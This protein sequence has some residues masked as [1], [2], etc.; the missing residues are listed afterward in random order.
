[1]VSLLQRGG[2][3]VQ[4]RGRLDDARRHAAIAPAL[5]ESDRG[6]A[7]ERDR[8][9]KGARAAR[10]GHRRIRELGLAQVNDVLLYARLKDLGMPPDTAWE[11]AAQIRDKLHPVA[12]VAAAKILKRLGDK[13]GGLGVLSVGAAGATKTVVGA[14]AGIAAGAA[15]GSVVPGIGTAV[16]AIA[17]LIAG[18][19][20]KQSGDP[21]RA[22][23]SGQIVN[24]LNAIPA[25]Y[26]GRTIPWSAGPPNIGLFQMIQAVMTLRIWLSWNAGL[27]RP[28]INGQWAQVWQGGRR[29]G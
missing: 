16:G 17:G 10:E 15:W 22:A 1:M 18:A 26:V 13:T 21:M 29:R 5:A 12:A 25:T 14:G 19:L 7:L 9:G 20:I 8:H 28:T 4:R 11:T 3:G 2:D 23:L 24:A 6:R 27:Q